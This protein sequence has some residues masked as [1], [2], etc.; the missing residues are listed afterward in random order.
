MYP[1][2]YVVT[3][4]TCTPGEHGHNVPRIVMSCVDTY[5]YR[6]TE[7]TL[8][9][10]ADQLGGLEELATAANQLL[11]ILRERQAADDAFWERQ[12]GCN[13]ILDIGVLPS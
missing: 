6:D 11:D 9:F 2:R 8:I 12:R 3:H 13:N 5:G 4:A 1:R 7:V 10:R